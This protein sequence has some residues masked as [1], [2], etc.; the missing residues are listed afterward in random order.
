MRPRPRGSTLSLISAPLTLAASQQ[1]PAGAYA[2]PS[3]LN[4]VL[5]EASRRGH[6]VTAK[7]LQD[8]MAIVKVERGNNEDMLQALGI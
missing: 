3:S 1:P 6:D 4:I 5:R 8:A 2:E 7:L